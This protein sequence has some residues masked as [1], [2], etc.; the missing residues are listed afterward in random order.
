MGE[1]LYW[2]LYWNKKDKMYFNPQGNY[3][4]LEIDLNKN[5]KWYILNKEHAEL[6]SS[7]DSFYEKKEEPQ[8]DK[9]ELNLKHWKEKYSDCFLT[10]EEEKEYFETPRK[11]TPLRNLQDFDS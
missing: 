9:F 6:E 8:I 7:P 4:T 2:I 3:K 10:A 11:A 5:K 1:P